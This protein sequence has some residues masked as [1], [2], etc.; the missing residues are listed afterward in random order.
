MLTLTD[1]AAE[2]IHAI[3][4]EQDAPEGVRI[5]TQA[6]PAGDTIFAITPSPGPAPQDTV[7]RAHDGDATVY[8]EPQAVLLLDDQIL[9]AQVTE[10]GEV[11]FL[12][13]EQHPG[14][15]TEQHPGENGRNS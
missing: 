5:T 6:Q 8:L 10:Q 7:V 11:T 3:T 9:D 14:E 2:V 13:T 15:F 12:F 1:N 4:T